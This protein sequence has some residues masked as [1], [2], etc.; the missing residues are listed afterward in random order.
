MLSRE[1]VDTIFF[2]IEQLLDVH[3]NFRDGLRRNLQVSTF[4]V[5]WFIVRRRILSA[6]IILSNLRE[7]KRRR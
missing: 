5:R 2:K 4:L 1:D 7:D 6:P 3:R